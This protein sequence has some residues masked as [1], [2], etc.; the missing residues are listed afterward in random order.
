MSEKKVVRRSVAIGLGIV[1]IL[2]IASLGGAMAY[3]V[4]TH[5]HSDSDYHSLSSQNTNLY[6]IVNLDDSTVWV[7]DTTVTQTANNYTSWD[8]SAS[9]AGY[10]SVNVQ[11]S[12][13]V[14]TY[15]EVIYSAYDINYDKKTIVSTSGTAA[16][17]VLFSPLIFMMNVSTSETAAFPLLPRF[18]ITGF[19]VSNGASG[20]PP[21]NLP[22]H[23]SVEIRVGNT[24]T[25]SNA[26]ETVTITY[27]Y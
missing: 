16:F 8:F 13:A 10:V 12:T 19:S 17:P 18:P 23:S 1:C 25:V 15:V 27:N 22:S 2:L 21:K 20:P 4:S 24:N 26:T 3:Y 6:N 14:T 9:Y 11:T 5:H 7:N